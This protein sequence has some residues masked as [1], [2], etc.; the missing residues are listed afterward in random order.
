MLYIISRFFAWSSGVLIEDVC[1]KF[2]ITQAIFLQ[3]MLILSGCAEGKKQMVVPASTIPVDYQAQKAEMLRILAEDFPELKP[4]ELEVIDSIPRMFFVKSEARHRAYL[5][6]TATQNSGSSKQNI[7]TYYALP[8]GS[9]QSTLRLSDIAFLLTALKVRPT[10]H[11]F[12]VGTGTG[13][14]TTILG[15]ISGQVYSMDII[16]QLVESAWQNMDRMNLSKEQVR[17]CRGNGLLLR[18]ELSPDATPAEIEAAAKSDLFSVA[19]DMRTR[20]DA[21]ILTENRAV[22][23]QVADEIASERLLLQRKACI[24]DGRNGMVGYAPY[25]ILLIT[26]PVKGEIPRDLLHL[27]ARENARVAAPVTD[28]NGNTDWIVYNYHYVDNS[29]EEIARQPVSANVVRPAK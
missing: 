15:R 10:D 29:L 4:N 9:G 7:H 17:I 3:L 20:M 14:L 13:Y 26:T 5:I 28:V 24:H 19:D 1:M 18:N 22:E 25:N 2:R 6:K 11:I 23:S 27:M 21:A 8:I 12:E 16:E